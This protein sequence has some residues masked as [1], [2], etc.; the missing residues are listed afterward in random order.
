[1]SAG[2]LNFSCM[3]FGGIS[4][5][6]G[7]MTGSNN[8]VSITPLLVSSLPIFASR[9]LSRISNGMDAAAKTYFNIALDSLNCAG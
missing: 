6:V 8:G 1:M 9:S 4:W 3:V 7:F 2:R 5:M